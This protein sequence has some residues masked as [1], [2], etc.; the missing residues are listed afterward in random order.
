[1]D[2]MEHLPMEGKLIFENVTKW[3]RLVREENILFL[4]SAK[5]EMQDLHNDMTQS[6]SNSNQEIDKLI[7]SYST[8][9][10]ISLLDDICTKISNLKDNTTRFK[11]Q[12]EEYSGNPPGRD[13][14]Q[15]SIENFNKFLSDL[16]EYAKTINFRIPWQ[17]EY[18]AVSNTED[19]PNAKVNFEGGKITD[20]NGR[21]IWAAICSTCDIEIQEG[22]KGQGCDRYHC[23]DCEKVDQCITCYNR[24]QKLLKMVP[25]EQIASLEQIDQHLHHVGCI[26]S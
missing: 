24:I 2:I 15:S 18:M 14:L 3:G 4:S 17:V 5:I 21:S 10:S 16:K 23:L 22:A 8:D 9:P 26:L 20:S 12:L 19:D 6:I 7:G 13:R 1:M 11:N 25:K